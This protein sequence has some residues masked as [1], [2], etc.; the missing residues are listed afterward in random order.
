MVSVSIFALCDVIRNI[1]SEFSTPFNSTS[2]TSPSLSVDLQILLDYLE[3]QLIQTY[4]PTR[5][6]NSDSSE[7]RDLIQGGSAYPDKISAYRNFTY[8]KYTTKHHGFREQEPPPE[9]VLEDQNVAHEESDDEVSEDVSPIDS[10][11][12]LADA[13]DLLLDQEEYPI[14]GDM[15]SYMTMVREAI[16]ELSQLQ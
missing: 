3:H 13:D 5:E 12:L 10:G 7:A 8:T 9:S 1:Q 16:D 2:H 6:N 14:D 15:E 4:T 11:D